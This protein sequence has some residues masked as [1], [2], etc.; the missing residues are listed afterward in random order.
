MDSFIGGTISHNKLGMRISRFM[1]ICIYYSFPIAIASF[2]LIYMYILPHYL[3]DSAKNHAWTYTK[4]YAA[5]LVRGGGFKVRYADSMY[6]A[7]RV[8]PVIEDDEQWMDDIRRTGYMYA[9]AFLAPFFLCVG[10]LIMN[11]RR[12]TRKLLADVFID[13]SRREPPKAVA[14]KIRKDGLRGTIKIGN[15]G[16]FMPDTYENKQTLVAGS[17]RVGKTNFLNQVIE[18]LINKFK[19]LIYT[20]EGD[21]IEKF[22]QHGHHIMNV[23]DERCLPWVVWN[24]IKT[25]PEITAFA[26]SLIPFSISKNDVFWQDAARA[27]MTGCMFWL[28]KKGAKTNAA[29]WELLTEPTEKILNK[30]KAIPQGARGVRF[31]EKPGSNQSQGV[32]A[33]LMQYAMTFEYLANITGDFS[34]TDWLRDEQEKSVIY[35]SS[36][37]DLKDVLRPSLSLFVDYLGKKM[38]T[39]LLEDESRK[40]YIFLDEIATLQRM[41]IEEFL[42]RG[43]KMGARVFIGAHSKSELNSVYGPDLANTMFSCLNNTISFRSVDKEM[44]VIMQDRFG[45]GQFD[46]KHINYTTGHSNSR[47]GVSI[48]THREMK[49]AIMDSTIGSFKDG[50]AGVKIGE[51]S[52]C[53]VQLPLKRYPRRAEKFKLRAGLEMHSVKDKFENYRETAE[54][55]KKITPIPEWYKEAQPKSEKSSLDQKLQIKE[56][57][58]EKDNDL[59]MDS[60]GIF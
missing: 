49:Q 54:E 40:I 16:L 44:Q 23:L 48:V 17:T 52:P 56:E 11:D 5:V 25:E 7:S 47:H 3:D 34:I 38:R 15:Q 39:K 2:I 55:I 13:G 35:L 28:Y 22:Y 24:D 26:S 43:G 30:L 4:A 20:I 57:M 42:T 51:Y 14:K 9:A 27:V 21:H 12:A 6:P 37:D 41:N 45:H 58:M 29:I 60:S 59:D 53:I 8:K 19:M 18:V 36:N 31:I 10:G 32:M 50:Q 1:Q 33:T 46:V